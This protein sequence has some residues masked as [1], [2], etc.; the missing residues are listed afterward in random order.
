MIQNQVLLVPPILSVGNS[1]VSLGTEEKDFLMR[2]LLN[3]TA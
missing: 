2:K 3:S 1:V